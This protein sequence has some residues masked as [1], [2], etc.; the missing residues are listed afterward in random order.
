MGFEEIY[1]TVPYLP[2]KY[3]FRIFSYSFIGNVFSISRFFWSANT[4]ACYFTGHA[5]Y[6]R[7]EFRMR[8]GNLKPHNRSTLKK[9]R[10]TATNKCIA[11]MRCGHKQRVA[12]AAAL[13]ACANMCAREC[14]CVYV[15]REE[16]W[17]EGGAILKCCF[18]A[19]SIMPT[20]GH[21]ICSHTKRVDG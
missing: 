16:R 13:T 1:N 15:Y 4:Q 14:V 2:I 20:F 5:S 12:H 19:V 6:Y 11:R 3:F 17:R 10:K 8:L 21:R 18:T 9:L 7:Q